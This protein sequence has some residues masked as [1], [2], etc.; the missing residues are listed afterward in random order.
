MHCRHLSHR[1]TV[2]IKKTALHPA[3]EEWITEKI[4]VVVAQSIWR[5]PTDIYE[6]EKCIYL[7]VDLAGLKPEAIDIALYE[8]ALVI[9][10]ERHLKIDGEAGVYHSA[11]IRQ[12]HF[13]L[14]ILLPTQVNEGHVE[15]Q[16][17]AGIL[18]VTLEKK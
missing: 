4:R 16:Y 12:G 17:E 13:R 10:G 2:L 5:P 9:E 14:E 3:S 8:D 1:Y 18:K 11:E 6:T 15:A 7:L